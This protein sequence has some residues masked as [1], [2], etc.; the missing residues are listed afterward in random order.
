MLVD[1]DH[2]LARDVAGSE[3]EFARTLIGEVYILAITI[4]AFSYNWLNA[5]VDELE[6]IWR[7]DCTLGKVVYIWM[8]IICVVFLS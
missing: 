3:A 8:R 5:F 6:F 1:L 4:T 7:K 2:L